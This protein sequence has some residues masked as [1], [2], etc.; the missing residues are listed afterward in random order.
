MVNIQKAVLRVSLR[1]LIQAFTVGNFLRDGRTIVLG[2]DRDT[3]QAYIVPE[4][5]AAGNALLARNPYNEEF[6]RRA[7]FLAVNK[8]P[9]GLTTDRAEFLGAR[10]SLARPAALERVGLT[11]AVRA[12]LD[13]CAV[14]Q[15]QCWL[16]PG[17]TEDV[18]FLLGQGADRAEA[19]R[20]AR[21]YQDA[22]EVERAWEEAGRFWDDLLGAVQVHTPDAA[23]T[24]TFFGWASAENTS[25]SLFMI[26]MDL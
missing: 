9:Y 23:M 16:A 5:A 6:G 2:S 21:Q 11:G 1:S 4:F 26:L 3:H 24:K 12:G 22:A 10:G 18:F 8:E 15:V 7:A 20:L 25:T 17:E 14:L 19:L 13:P